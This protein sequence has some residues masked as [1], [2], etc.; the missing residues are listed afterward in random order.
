MNPKTIILHKIKAFTSLFL[1]F[2][3]LLPNAIPTAS[4]FA[5]PEEYPIKLSITTD[6]QSVYLDWTMMDAGITRCNLM[7]ATDTELSENVT[8]WEFDVQ[9]LR[10]ADNLVLSD[11]TYYYRVVAYSDSE[12]VGESNIESISLPNNPEEYRSTLTA[13]I[14]GQNILLQWT[15]NF[16]EA[17]QV[18]LQRG[19][20][21]EF[22]ENLTIL[23]VDIEHASYSDNT[24]LPG[25]TYYYRLVSQDNIARLWQSNIVSI[26][27]PGWPVSDSTESLPVPTNLKAK[28][29]DNLVVLSWETADSNIIGFRIE[30]SINEDFSADIVTIQT[31]NA[32]LSFSDHNVLAGATYYYRVYALGLDQISAASN[33]AEATVLATS[34]NSS[35][36]IPVPQD[37]S[38]WISHSQQL[39]LFWTC[40]KTDVRGFFIIRAKDPGFKESLVALVVKGGITLYT[41]NTVE[42]G[43][44][45]YYRVHTWSQFGV[46][47]P[48]GVIAVSLPAGDNPVYREE[49][50]SPLNISLSP[51]GPKQGIL[52]WSNEK[53]DGLG[54]LILRST[55]AN[56]VENVR[57]TKVNAGNTNCVDNAIVPGVEYFYRIYSWDKTRISASFGTLSVLVPSSS[58][59]PQ[60]SLLVRPE[61]RVEIKSPS[62]KLSLVI[63]QGAVER[64]TQIVVTE[65]DC[66]ADAAFQPIEGRPPLSLFSLEATD[67]LTAKNVDVFR[68]N[69]EIRIQHDAKDWEVVDPESLH[70]YYLNEKTQQWEIVSG[71]FN[72]DTNQL[73]ATTN[74]FSVYG[75]QG[76]PN[77]VGPGRVMASQVNLH[78]GT[79]TYSYP[80]EL[81]IGPGGFQPKL[82]LQYNSGSVDE[83]KDRL[84]VGSWV[85]MGWSL[86]LGQIGFNAAEGKYYLDL[87]GSSY[88]L[89]ASGNEYYTKPVSNYKITCSNNTW[90]M[91]DREGVTYVFG[92][93]DSSRLYINNG[94]SKTY[95]SW[96]LT[97]MQDTNGNKATVGYV[98]DIMGSSPNE[99]VRSIYPTYMRY[100]Y[101]DASTYKM[102]V[103]FNIGHDGATSDGYLR[104][105]NPVSYSWYESYQCVVGY[106]W[107]PDSCDGACYVYFQW[108]Y[109][110]PPY[111]PCSQ[112]PC[113]IP[114]H[115]DYS[116][117]IYGTCYSSGSSP[118]PKVMESRRLNSIDVK[119]SG[120]TLRKYVFQLH[121]YDPGL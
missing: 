63:P 84:A 37:L 19:T 83:M 107:I 61:Q 9:T 97:L 11:I 45:Y 99:W 89:T 102:E 72:R 98:Q 46:S 60:T 88:E 57:V 75:E 108:P 79:A 44:T 69:L 29:E 14:D 3:L 50:P 66:E 62:G 104:S 81:P 120:S 28:V 95:Y 105:D 110:T 85:G 87:N 77:I 56:F 24:V 30:K 68:D 65:H 34:D 101:I 41:D 23:E 42:A 103:V 82:E 6:N 121:H 32:L 25:N 71:T 112:T 96:N 49:L 109:Y 78:A 90:T 20:N 91:L 114:G 2:A 1:I 53:T 47:P 5:L 93:S 12:K 8:S 59:L 40:N 94:G 58:K 38:A 111:P 64:Q 54:F 115:Y 27:V 15:D 4:V 51:T 31:G 116:Q 76:N 55:D 26:S 36:E 17:I 33:V 100:G 119:V 106:A 21:F 117:P 10:Y 92:D 39:L 80:L 18:S 48:S 86:S 67:I 113:Y 70:L 43:S 7:R 52:N 118:A 22:S 35:K 16:P 73:V 13:S 74:H